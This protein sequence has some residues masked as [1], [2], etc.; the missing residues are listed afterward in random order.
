[1]S[2]DFHKEMIIKTSRSGGKGG[3]NV[4]KVETQ[5]EARFNIKTSNLLSTEQ[6]D[7]LLTALANK[8]TKHQE[9][10]VICNE[11]RTQLENKEIVVEKLNFLIN[12][13]LVKPKQRRKTAIPKSVHARRLDG[14]KLRGQI[15]KLRSEKLSW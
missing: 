2:I 7:F 12:K 10:I 15:K 11:K 1:M 4:N 8:L 6:K 13:H 3:Q 9:L 5:V 14:K